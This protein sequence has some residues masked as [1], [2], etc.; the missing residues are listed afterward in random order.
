MPGSQNAKSVF[1]VVRIALLKTRSGCHRW[2]ACFVN[3]ACFDT[4]NF[5]FGVYFDV[6]IAK[7]MSIVLA[8]CTYCDGL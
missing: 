6:E 5:D 2:L 7:I 1:Q 4:S 8:L 3:H